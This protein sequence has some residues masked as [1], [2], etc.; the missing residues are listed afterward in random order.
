MVFRQRRLKL[1]F[2]GLD[3]G[4]TYKIRCYAYHNE[5][6]DEVG[7]STTSFKIESPPEGG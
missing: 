4:V 5:T 7:E 2:E 1:A 3:A 6:F